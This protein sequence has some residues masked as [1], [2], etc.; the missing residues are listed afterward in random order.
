MQKLIFYILL[1]SFFLP[2][3]SFAQQ[4]KEELTKQRQAIQ[5]EIDELNASLN[6]IRD[7]KKISLRELEARQRKVE[8]RQDLINN[9]NKK[10]KSL[11]DE[12]YLK[13]VEIYRLN[14]E[15][16]T[17]RAKYKQS[18]VYAYKNRSN[19]QYLNFLF[20]S[21]SFNDALKRIAYL[22]GYRKMREEEAARITKTQNF[23]AENIAVL[24]ATKDDKKQTLVA[25]NEQL[26]NLEQDKKE[27]E[28]AV[29]QIRGQEQE[30]NAQIAKKEKQRRE[31]NVA[32]NLAIKKEIAEAQRKEKER[33]A[34]LKAAEDLRRKQ[35]EAEA[36]A[37]RAAA[38]KAKADAD[39]KAKSDAAAKAK[40]DADAKKAEEL[41]KK[42]EEKSVTYNAETV[43]TGK[44]IISSTGKK[45]EYNEFEGTKEGLK[46]SENF[47]NYKHRLLW[48]VDVGTVCGRFGTDNINKIRVVRDGIEICLP[49]GTP[50]K[51]VA[52]GVVSKVLDMG[53]YQTVMI[54]HGKYLTIYN[55]LA[56][57]TVS[58]GQTVGAGTL[59]GKAA[60]ADDGDG[61]IEFRVMNGYS[62]FENPENW[63]K[64]R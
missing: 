3:N 38:I 33:L 56:N 39:A 45:R 51:C 4:T 49:V 31:V 11:D 26:Q 35:L 43:N 6:N 55:K 53:D 19:Y 12:L 34:K 40:A 25:Q 42:A 10:V 15:L 32:I 61:E 14:K 50:V 52:D 28:D 41:A 21:T 8:A 17:L 13:Q 54:R 1:F 16:D 46:M 20:S 7:R 36:A 5:K 47:E 59:V 29:K 37:A 24:N 2:L 57:I 58:E 30:I 23:L 63:L 9:I 22:K 48:P 60:T 64:T 62:K 18:I 27:Q 44:T